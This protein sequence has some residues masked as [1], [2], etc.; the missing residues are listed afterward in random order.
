[1]QPAKFETLTL[2]AAEVRFASDDAGTFT[3]YASVF[4]EADSYGDIIKAGAFKKSIAS[5]AKNGGVALFW[6]H[7]SDQPIGIWTELSE[8]AKGLK[9]AA[10]LVTETVRGAE[11]LAL[12]KAGAV[13]G[14]SI[15]FRAI[16]SE[17]GANGARVLTEI[18]L[19]EISV[20]ALPAASKAR[21][22]SV[23]SSG[24]SDSSHFIA[25]VKA[26]TRSIMKAK[27]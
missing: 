3:G 8:D 1:M 7:S 14:L 18:D 16:S 15:G 9:V 6:N 12:I 24:Q 25:A 20:V 21:I 5:R 4:G 22:N 2:N 19:I 23:R 13:S 26:A 17:R 10:K 27:K 11:T